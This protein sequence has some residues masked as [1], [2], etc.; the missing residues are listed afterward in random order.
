MNYLSQ[1]ITNPSASYFAKALFSY[2]VNQPDQALQYIENAKQ[3]NEFT[4]YLKAL[5]LYK[6]QQHQAALQV[7]EA[8]LKINPR[9]LLFSTLKAQINEQKAPISSADY[10]YEE[11]LIWRTNIHHYQQTEPNL[12]LT[13]KALLDFHQGKDKEAQILIRR[14]IRNVQPNK[15][16]LP[17]QAQHQIHLIKDAEEQAGLED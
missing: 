13:Y 4:L 2:L 5:I 8:V 11:R 12:A 3:D 17:E 1:Q 16:H 6:T 10:L 14:A 9:N 7:L 15:R